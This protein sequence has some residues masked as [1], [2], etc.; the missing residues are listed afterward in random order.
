MEV[1]VRR[2][3]GTLCTFQSIFP[4]KLLK[5]IVYS[6]KE[7]CKVEKERERWS[8][9]GRAERGRGGNKKEKLEINPKKNDALKDDPPT[10]S[11]NLQSFRDM[12]KTL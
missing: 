7:K 3:M 4:L 2:C 11:L 10:Q 8:R 5:I 12:K 1:G 6:F 9:C